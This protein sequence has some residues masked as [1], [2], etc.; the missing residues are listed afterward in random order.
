MA[1]VAEIKEALLADQ[2]RAAEA[3][4]VALQSIGAVTSLA[5][6]TLGILGVVLGLVA[7]FGW[8]V[9]SKVATSRAKELAGQKV[10]AYLISDEFAKI[11]DQRVVAAMAAR[12][13]AKAATR[14]VTVD[15]ADPFPPAK[16][17]ET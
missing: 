12:D 16:E 7:L 4:E 15:D 1:S 11:L 2:Q 13:R 8:A 9:I 3:Y 17:D 6:W 5:S 14:D 10:S